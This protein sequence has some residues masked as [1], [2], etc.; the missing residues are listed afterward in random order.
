MRILPWIRIHDSSANPQG[1]VMRYWMYSA[2]WPYCMLAIHTSR[3]SQPHVYIYIPH[4]W[5]DGNLMHS[6]TFLYRRDFGHRR[7]PL[8]SLRELSSIRM[9][10]IIWIP[11]TCKKR[12]LSRS[13]AV[14][15]AYCC[16]LLLSRACSPMLQKTIQ[17]NHMTRARIRSA[18]MTLMISK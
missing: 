16:C 8:I 7:V 18:T 6:C 10:S 1:W 9:D 2:I 3:A 5:V 15:V 12:L 11:S 17:Y 14:A 4:I 13:V